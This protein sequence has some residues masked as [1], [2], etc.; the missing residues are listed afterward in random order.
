[1]PRGLKLLLLSAFCVTIILTASSFAYYEYTLQSANNLLKRRVVEA[2]RAIALTAHLE[3]LRKIPGG[4]SVLLGETVVAIRGDGSSV[5]SIARIGNDGKMVNEGRRLELSDG[6]SAQISDDIRTV[7]ALKVP[8][9]QMAR[10]LN[11]YDLRYKCATRVGEY[12]PLSSRVQGRQVL[13]YDTVGYIL[14]SGNPRISIW[15]APTLG[16]LEVFREEE[17]LD[18]AKEIVG[19]I[20][21]EAVKIVLGEPEQYLFLIPSAYDHVSFSEHFKRGLEKDNSPVPVD[22]TSRFA[23][24]DRM[25]E[26]FKQ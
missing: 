23:A 26:K 24:E 5:A 7:T 14:S 25:Y 13:G 16:C 9:A 20:E 19:T 4:G 8:D 18:E 2:P 15:M 10:A 1:M 12:D 22:F 17:S 21:T 3:R 11:R 6:T